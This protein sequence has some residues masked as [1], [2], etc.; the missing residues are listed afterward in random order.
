MDEMMDR[1]ISPESTP[2][3]DPDELIPVTTDLNDQPEAA[4]DSGNTDP[5]AEISVLDY[6]KFKLNPKNF[7]K[8]ILPEV[9]PTVYDGTDDGTEPTATE[10]IPF[11]AKVLDGRELVKTRIN[12]LFL[13]LSLCFALT[14]Q[15]ILEPM[16]MARTR[17][18]PWIGSGFYLLSAL[19]FLFSFLLRKPQG[20]E[21]NSGSRIEVRG[22]GM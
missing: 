2:V 1:N 4:D 12:P 10:K 11:F 6:L 14:A 21:T 13:A 18:T 7:G 5:Y 17:M 20:E 22:S 9:N 15:I 8:E 16:I 19:S 3:E